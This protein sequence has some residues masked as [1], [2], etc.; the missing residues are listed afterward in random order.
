MDLEKIAVGKIHGRR[1]DRGR[2]ISN[3]SRLIQ[4]QDGTQ[5][6]RRGRAVEKKALQRGA[7]DMVDARLAQPL[8]HALQG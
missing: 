2:V 4:Y 5:V 3:V 6:S 8:H 1:I 7:I